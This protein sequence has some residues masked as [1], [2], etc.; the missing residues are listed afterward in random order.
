MDLPKWQRYKTT[1]A[2]LV[3]L[4]ISGFSKD[5]DPTRL[6]RHRRNFFNAVEETWLFSEAKEAQAVR[7]HFLGD[8]LRLAFRAEV[9][10]PQVSGFV[11]DVFAGLDR[12]NCQV[13]EPY[14]T[15]LKGVALEGVV[16]WKTWLNCDYLD[17]ELP[18]KAQTWMGQ[19][20]PNEVAIDED[21]RQSLQVGGLPTSGFPS[22][23]F[24][25]EIGYLLR[26]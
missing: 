19:L 14:R 21:F 9:E 1:R 15:K 3:A 16:V 18:F 7:A 25:G 22:K 26:S 2:F 13:L 4:D 11:D 24:S 20:A 10:A 5:L 17:G 12:I 6:L 23:K 8:E